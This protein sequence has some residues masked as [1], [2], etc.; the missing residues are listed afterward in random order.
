LPIHTEKGDRITELAGLVWCI[1]MES[2]VTDS[3]YRGN[4]NPA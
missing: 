4:S 3:R 1:D 2:A